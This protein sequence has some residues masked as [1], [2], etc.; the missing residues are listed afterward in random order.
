MRRSVGADS[1]AFWKELFSLRFGNSAR[2][3]LPRDASSAALYRL[4]QLNLRNGLYVLNE[5][6]PWGMMFAGKFEEGFR[7]TLKPLLPQTSRSDECS[8]TDEMPGFEIAY[9]RR[10]G[11]ITSIRDPLG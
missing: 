6:Y 3:A 9:D 2:M 8:F 5:A 4:M 10:T 11:R 1:E 7:F